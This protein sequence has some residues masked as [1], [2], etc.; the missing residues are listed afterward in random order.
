[1]IRKILK[2]E[3]AAPKVLLAQEYAVNGVGGLSDV[4]EIARLGGDA[5]RVAGSSKRQ[6]RRTTVNI[7]GGSSAGGT[8]E[9]PLLSMTDRRRREVTI[10][11]HEVLKTAGVIRWDGGLLD[12]ATAIA[13]SDIATRQIIIG[14]LALNERG[15][16]RRARSAD[17]RQARR[18][19]EVDM[20]EQ[21]SAPTLSGRVP[22]TYNRFQAMT[23]KHPNGWAVAARFDATGIEGPRPEAVSAQGLEGARPIWDAEWDQQRYGSA[24][25]RL[26]SEIQ[27]LVVAHHG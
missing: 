18:E 11:M 7:V 10:F 27:P 9:A 26:A 8:T 5:L 17:W 13:V 16:D 4:D 15:A 22:A 25:S 19:L 1:M 14:G 23:G 3:Q 21:G 12:E 6:I 2:R 20:G 24:A